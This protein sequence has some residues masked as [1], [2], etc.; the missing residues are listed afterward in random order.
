MR[1]LAQRLGT[2]LRLAATREE[3]QGLTEYGLILILIGIVV[4]LMLGILGHQVTNAY[5]NI[6]GSLSNT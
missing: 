1:V 3:G 4:V 5:S 2:W 6:N